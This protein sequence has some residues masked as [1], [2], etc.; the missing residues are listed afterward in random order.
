MDIDEK[1]FYDRLAAAHI[2]INKLKIKLRDFLLRVE[3][4]SDRTDWPLYLSLISQCASELSEIRK[5]AESDRFM[6]ASY[7]LVTPTALTTVPDPNLAKLTEDR[8]PVIN[9]ETVPQYLRTKLDPQIEQQCQQQDAK[10]SAAYNPEQLTKLI[11]QMNKLLESA[12]KEVNHMRQEVDS[13]LNASEHFHSRPTPIKSSRSGSP[14]QS[15]EDPLTECIAAITCGTGVS[16][17]S[18]K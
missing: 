10:L 8:L 7:V 3:A 12:L 4:N 16:R 18:S 1:G 15:Q 5:F 6:F 17:S 14:V 9:H 11:N 2:S 13:D